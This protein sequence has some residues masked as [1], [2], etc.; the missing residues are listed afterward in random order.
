M[1]RT[2]ITAGTL[3]TAA[4]GNEFAQLSSDQPGNG[5]INGSFE[6][7]Q[8]GTSSLA[9]A[10]SSANG[11]TAD[12]WQLARSS[13]VTGATVSQATGTGPCR[14]AARVQRT[15]GNTALNN[16]FLYQTLETA[17]A[18]LY[19][20]QQVTFSAWVRKGIDFNSST[21]TMRI[22]GGTGTDQNVIAGFTGNTTITSVSKT[23]TTSWQQV[24]VTATVGSTITELACGF[25][26][27]P[28]GTAGAADYFEITGAQLEIS[29]VPTPFR[30][31][32]GSVAGEFLAC[33]RYF[34]RHGLVSGNAVATGFGSGTTTTNF[35]LA[36]S[37]MRIAP[38][39]VAYTN[40]QMVDGSGGTL[41]LT[42]LAAWNA[43][44]TRIGV[45]ATHATNDT[46]HRPYFLSCSSSAGYIDLNAEI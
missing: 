9:T 13:Y 34:Q 29:P 40:L 5:L 41:A 42:A 17:N 27:T 10:T 43:T 16:I 36:T 11:F 2:T 15:A 25:L 46:A 8:R 33:Q 21:F 32:S 14:Y 23:L 1:A 38:S 45:V 3:I 19:A 31:S 6:I 37:P 20:G 18:E 12:R 35:H 22:L 4:Q 24:S 39:S 30:H 26:W 7:W 44:P 28:V